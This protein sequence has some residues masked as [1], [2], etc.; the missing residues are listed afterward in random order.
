MPNYFKA[1]SHS[2]FLPLRLCQAMGPGEVPSLI[3]YAPDKTWFRPSDEV[4]EWLN[5]TQ[6]DYHISD[7]E[8]HT[9]GAHVQIATKQ[10]VAVMKLAFNL[11]EK[12]DV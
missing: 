9:D 12:D 4:I 2:V 6:T 1:H 10:E 11:G 5:N 8:Y 7:F 3:R